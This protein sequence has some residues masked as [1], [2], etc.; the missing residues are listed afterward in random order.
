MLWLRRIYE[1]VFGLV[2]TMF[3]ILLPRPIRTVDVFNWSA[4]PSLKY[5]VLPWNRL[6]YDFYIL[7]QSIS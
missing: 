2:I 4:I 1:Q 7:V 3:S 6:K 5:P